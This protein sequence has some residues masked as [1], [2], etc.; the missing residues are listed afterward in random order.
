[1]R[2]GLVGKNSFGIRVADTNCPSVVDET[3]MP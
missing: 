2:L 1:M 3:E